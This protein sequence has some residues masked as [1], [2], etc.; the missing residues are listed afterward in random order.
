[1][2][3]LGIMEHLLNG[4]KSTAEEILAEFFEM[5]TSEGSVEVDTLK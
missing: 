3:D 5:G 4:V 2:L 1:M